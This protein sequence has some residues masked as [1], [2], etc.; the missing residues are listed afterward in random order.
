MRPYFPIITSVALIMTVTVSPA[1]RPRASAERRVMA[2][3]TLLATD[4]HHHFGHDG[5]QH[6]F[7]HAAFEL[8]AGAD[9]H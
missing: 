2:D 6:D 4:V 9:L 8:V 1:L 7:L 5:A 3:A